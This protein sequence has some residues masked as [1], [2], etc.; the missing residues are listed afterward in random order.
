MQFKNSF[1]IKYVIHSKLSMSKNK[2]EFY[3]NTL[4]LRADV[5][6]KHE[7]F[8]ITNKTLTTL[9]GIWFVMKLN[10]KVMNKQTRNNRCP[11]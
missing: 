5:H 2:H 7:S 9:F 11:E 4:F 3:Q 10:T 8:T 6:K 1:L